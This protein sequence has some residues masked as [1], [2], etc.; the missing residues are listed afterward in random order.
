MKLDFNKLENRKRDE[1]KKG[2]RGRCPAC[3]EDGKDAKGEHLL[4]YDDEDFNCIA[5]QSREHRLRIK[6]ILRVESPEE[7]KV[8]KAIT[9]TIYPNKTVPL[10]RLE[11]T[12]RLGQEI[13]RLLDN[14]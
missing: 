14:N 10:K 9:F 5:D 2:W 13:K 7:R 8:K 3:K 6:E 1:A 12:G 11:L 4:I